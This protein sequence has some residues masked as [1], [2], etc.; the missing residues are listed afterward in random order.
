[1]Y[2]KAGGFVMGGRAGGQLAISRSIGDH[3]LRGVGVIPNPSVQR[4]IIK[5]TD[6]WVV[7]ATDGVWDSMTDKDVEELIKLKE[8]PV[9]K[10]AQKI[11]KAA[12]DKGSQDNITCLVIKL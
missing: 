5:T 7:I 2:R 12:M 1:M 11:I 8:E 6:H 10:M 4:V 9:N 3:S